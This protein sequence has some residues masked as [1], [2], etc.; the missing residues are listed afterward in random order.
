M[1]LEN[2]NVKAG[3]SAIHAA[4]ALAMPNSKIAQSD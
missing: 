1:P 2:Q 3:Q 4:I